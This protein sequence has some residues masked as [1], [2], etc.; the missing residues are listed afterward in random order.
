M[1]L[2]GCVTYATHQSPVNISTESCR[3][4]VMPAK[5]IQNIGNQLIPTPGLS[6]KK[7]MH[8]NTKVF[9]GGLSSVYTTMELQQ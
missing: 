2:A 3:N 8:T 9:S 5:S 4:Y 1:V 6:N 7:S